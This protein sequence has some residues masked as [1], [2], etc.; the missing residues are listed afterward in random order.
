MDLIL[1]DIQSLTPGYCN[2]H[3]R[4]LCQARYCVGLQI[5]VFAPHIKNLAFRTAKRFIDPD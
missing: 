3:W 4:T 5:Y 1:Y 2:L